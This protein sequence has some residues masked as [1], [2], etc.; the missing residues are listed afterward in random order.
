MRRLIPFSAHMRSNLAWE[1]LREGCWPCH[2]KQ[3]CV[4]QRRQYVDDSTELYS[5]CKGGEGLEAWCWK[6]LNQTAAMPKLQR[7]PSVER[8]GGGGVTHSCAWQLSDYT[9]HSNSSWNIMHSETRR[10]ELEEQRECMDT[11]VCLLYVHTEIKLENCKPGHV[12]EGGGS[13]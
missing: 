5:G 1:T 11:W 12:Q 7:G 13:R 2:L 3:Y 8:W 9:S 6:D 10:L 4:G